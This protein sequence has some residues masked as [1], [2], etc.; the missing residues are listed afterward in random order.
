MK[1]S[2]KLKKVYVLT[3]EKEVLLTTSSQ[4]IQALMTDLKFK[5]ATNQY[6]LVRMINGDFTPYNKGGW[7]L[8]FKTD[9]YEN[10]AFVKYSPKGNVITF[11]TFYGEDASVNS[12]EILKDLLKSKELLKDNT[13]N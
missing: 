4:E 2:K 9:E 13:F 7:E 12:S 5:M 1:S 8:R 3:E 6:W 10:V 11:D